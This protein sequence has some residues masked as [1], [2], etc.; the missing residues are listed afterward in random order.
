MQPSKKSVLVIG[1]VMLDKWVYLKSIRTSPETN[2]PIVRVENE[3]IEMGGAGNALRHLVNISTGSHEF[4]GVIGHDAAGQKLLEISNSIDANMQLVID[5]ERKTTVKERYFLDNIPIYRHDRESLEDI[6]KSIEYELFLAIQKS[7]SSKDSVL[8][9]DYAKGVLSQNLIYNV[10]QLA[11]SLS[12]PIISDPG[13]GRIQMH[14]GC[15]II[16]PNAKEWNVYI[17]EMGSET[18]ALSKLFS[19]GTKSVVVT[20]GSGGIRLIEKGIDIVSQADHLTDA[21]DVT[22]AGDSV[23]A[24]LSILVDSDGINPKILPILNSVGG[25]TVSKSRTEL[26]S[27]IQMEI[28]R[29]LST[30]K[31]GN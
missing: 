10:I 22:G 19:K 3:F 18:V 21:T 1:D 11:K 24:A 26:P 12:K 31:H 17:E 30:T 14:A 13:L 23:A 20:Q 28:S 25:Q 16:K 4:I 27:G 5:R 7:M 2:S 15:D 9:S 29:S 6:D 8:L